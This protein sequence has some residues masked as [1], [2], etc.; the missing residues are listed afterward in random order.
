MPIRLDSADADFEQQFTRLLAGKREASQDVNDTV[1]AIIADVRARGDAA[2]VEHTN[3]LDR[4]GVSEQTL[5]IG[6]DEVAAAAARVSDEVRA[7]LP[8]SA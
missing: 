1:A 4:A 5:Q 2:V 3:R 8:S 7:A 6:A